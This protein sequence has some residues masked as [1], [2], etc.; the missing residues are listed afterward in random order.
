MRLENLNFTFI[1][2]WYFIN[3]ME[4]GSF[5]GAAR[6]LNVTQST[7]RKSVSSLETNLE[8]QLFSRE[9]KGLTATEAGRFLYTRW[10]TMLEQIE[11]DLLHAQRY[12]GGKRKVLR[13]GT[14]TS[15]R[16]EEFLLDYVRRF[17]EFCP[18]CEIE[19]ERT[20][21]DV[22]RKK[23]LE[24]E[25]DVVFTVLYETEYASWP[26]CE[27]YQFRSCPHVAGMLP[28]NPLAG[29]KSV[30][31]HQMEPMN[32]ISISTLYLPTYN[33]MLYDLFAEEGIRPNIVY[34]TANASSQVYHL[35]GP[36]DI[37]I[38]DRYHRDYGLPSLVY[39]PIEHTRSGVSMVWRKGG[40]ST[41]LQKFL[42]LFES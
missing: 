12:S 17:S 14:L 13:I 36:N 19:I 39:L 7:L 22:L 6:L 34:Q 42:N 4:S 37:F 16:S 11:E 1:Q 26:N 21:T 20:L 18:K 29:K 3:V 15:H 5:A 30:T 24:G 27:F 28:S 35:H 33:Q 25:L 9:G 23:L 31:V 41:E 8:M 40:R 38:C 10:K 32:L 2:V